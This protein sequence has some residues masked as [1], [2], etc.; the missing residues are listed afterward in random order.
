MFDQG[1][2]QRPVLFGGISYRNLDGHLAS[3]Q[4]A[5]VSILRWDSRSC[6]CKLKT[7]GNFTKGKRNG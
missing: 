4:L 5:Y 3:C 1:Y 7:E 2:A 6:L